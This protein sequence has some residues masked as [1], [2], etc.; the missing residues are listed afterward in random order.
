MGEMTLKQLK[1]LPPLPQRPDVLW[2]ACPRCGNGISCPGL[3]GIR[4][5]KCGATHDRLA[6]V[7]DE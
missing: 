1:K 7:G 5:G 3:V 6:E 4:C 2:S